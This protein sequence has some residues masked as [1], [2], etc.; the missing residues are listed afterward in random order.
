MDG[1][2][3][4]DLPGAQYLYRALIIFVHQ[5]RLAEQ[6]MVHHE[7]RLACRSRLRGK[8]PGKL[9]QI[10]YLRDVSLRLIAKTAH[11]WKLQ[12]DV[13]LR[14]TDPVPGAG[15]LSFYAATGI[16][17]ALAVAADALGLAS[18][19]SFEFVKFHDGDE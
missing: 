13:A 3:E 16:T 19:K 5:L 1:D 18:F 6:L 15:T 4:S 8:R 7:R 9:A 17:A 14:R 11:L 2:R 12:D 10:E